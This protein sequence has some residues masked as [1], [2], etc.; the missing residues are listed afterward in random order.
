MNERL[1]YLRRW[2]ACSDWREFLHNDQRWNSTS[3]AALEKAESWLTR[4]GARADADRRYGSD[5]Y[6]VF[7]P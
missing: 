7:V 1:A 2:K 4:G 3:K 6:T 5:K